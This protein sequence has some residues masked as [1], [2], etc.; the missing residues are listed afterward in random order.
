MLYE[1]M[2]TGDNEM[3]PKARVSRVQKKGQV[4]IPQEI[5]E[6]LG[7]EEGDLVAF[8]ET[9]DGVLISPQAVVDALSLSQMETLLEERGFSFESFLRVPPYRTG[10]P[11]PEAETLSAEEGERIADAT[12]GIF[13]PQPQPLDFKKLR[14]QF[15]ET[16]AENAAAELPFEQA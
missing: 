16:T 5:R 10:Q 12:A 11:L 7:I 1:S 4:T 2:T 13:G 14:R 15:I 6:R 3:G 8:V 9:A